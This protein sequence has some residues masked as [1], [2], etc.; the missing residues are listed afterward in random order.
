MVTPK[1]TEY[2]VQDQYSQYGT[3]YGR[4]LCPKATQTCTLQSILALLFVH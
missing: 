2:R 3:H 1:S 4:K